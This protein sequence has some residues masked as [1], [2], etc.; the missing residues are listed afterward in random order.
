[1]MKKM[2]DLERSLTNVFFGKC[3]PSLFVAVLESLVT[4]HATFVAENNILTAEL[5]STL[6]LQ[7]IAQ[8][9]EGLDDASGLL[10]SFN[11]DAARKDDKANLFQEDNE[12]VASLK[13]EITRVEDELEDHLRDCGKKLG[14]KGLAYKT[15]SGET[16]LI[17]L[18]KPQQKAAKVPSSWERISGTKTADRYR[19]PFIIDQLQEM[20]Q[21]KERLD[22]EASNAWLEFLERFAESYDQYRSVVS[23]LAVLDCLMSLGKV[24]LQP[25]FVRA[26]LIDSESCS[27]SITQGRNPVVLALQ[28]NAQF[29]PND[30]FL[31]NGCDGERC[32]IVTGPNMGGKSCYIRQVALIAILAQIGSYVPAEAAELAP[33]DAIYT[34]M[35][36]EDNLFQ[37]RSTFMHEL[38][39]A[40]EI[41][42]SASPRSLVIMDELGRGTSTH[43]G[44]AIAHATCTY[45]VEHLR[46]LTLFVT[47]YPSIASLAETLVESG[48]KPAIGNFHMSFI[49]EN[50]TSAD[51]AA[52]KITFLYKLVRGVAARSYG[53]NVARLADIPMPIIN[54]AGKKSRELEA[55]VQQ[56]Q[57]KRETGSGLLQALKSGNDAEILRCFGSVLPK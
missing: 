53:L 7:A 1:M 18:T 40:S 41:L 8:I 49:E 48:S 12:A 36:A 34:R 24:A 26:K 33:L 30:A 52:T 20:A 9:S 21:F 50:D 4:V 39:E 5:K 17:E 25:D 43:D 23:S 6:L 2:P 57:Q 22:A 15:V 31:S 51:E 45:L 55:V 29:V 38:L 46:C 16:H 44:V 54:I 14:M 37:K 42:E 10:A 13:E 47:H 56:R 3:S 27:I 19:S 11:K 32:Y 28:D 35:G